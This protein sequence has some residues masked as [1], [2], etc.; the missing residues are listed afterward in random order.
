[1]VVNF[2][3]KEKEIKI[4]INQSFKDL[5]NIIINEFNLKCKN[6]DLYLNIKNPI[7]GLGK[8]TLEKGIIHKSM[9]NYT[10]DNFNIDGKELSLDFLELENDYN[11]I[12]TPQKKSKKNQ[13]SFIKKN[14]INYNDLDEFPE[15]C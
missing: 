6:V 1:M 9:D 12:H 13:N 3:I 10:M 11:T 2:I 14:I 5:K 4:E 7:R 8:Y 15:L